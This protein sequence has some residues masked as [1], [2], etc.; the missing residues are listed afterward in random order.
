MTENKGMD[1]PELQTEFAKDV[2]VFVI[3]LQM[4]SRKNVPERVTLYVA[5]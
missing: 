5:E 4:I 2:E 3:D 1:A